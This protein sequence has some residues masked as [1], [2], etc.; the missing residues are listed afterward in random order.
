MAPSRLRDTNKRCDDHHQGI[1]D[2]SEKR[3]AKILVHIRETA[4]DVEIR[5]LAAYESRSARTAFTAVRP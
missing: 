5:P 4:P 1:P 2:G 3:T